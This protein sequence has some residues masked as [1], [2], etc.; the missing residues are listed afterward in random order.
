[1]RAR[2]TEKERERERERERE[3]ERERETERQRETENGI[4]RGRWKRKNHVQCTLYN[5]GIYANFHIS[6]PGYN[7]KN[8][9]LVYLI[10]VI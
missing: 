7:N 10:L 2:E 4:S 5:V 6:F 8:M 9:M 1:M 3:S